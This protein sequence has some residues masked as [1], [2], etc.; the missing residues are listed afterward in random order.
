[1]QQWRV[2]AVTR[3][4]RAR[5]ANTGAARMHVFRAAELSQIYRFIIDKQQ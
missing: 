1:M 5:F 2:R 4:H 3:L